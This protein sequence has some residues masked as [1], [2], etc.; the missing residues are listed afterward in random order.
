MEKTWDYVEP[1]LKRQKIYPTPHPG[2][3]KKQEKKQLC[4]WKVK[5]GEI[6]EG[7]VKKK[8]RPM[9]MHKVLSVQYKFRNEGL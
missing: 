9:D 8:S 6:Y 7:G 4:D 5:S 2:G 1:S 3:H